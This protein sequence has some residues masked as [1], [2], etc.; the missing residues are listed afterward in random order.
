MKPLP[1]TT[2]EATSRPLKTSETIARLVARDIVRRGLQTGERLPGEAA[3]IEHYGVSRE[4]LREALRLLEVQGL[5]TIKRGVGGGPLVGRVDPANLGRIA[6]LFFYMA[7]GTYEELFQAWEMVEATLAEM[8]ARNPDRE[9]VRSA[10]EPFVTDSGVVGRDLDGFVR[11]HTDFHA[12]LGG[13]MGNRV[14]ELMLPTLGQIVTHHIVVHS[15]PRK[16]GDTIHGDH[17]AIARAVAS[18]QPSNARRL[19]AGHIRTMA[20]FFNDELG[21]APDLIDW[22]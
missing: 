21:A 2:G 5:I 4:S 10:M 15:D 22:K 20:A 19:M 12:V 17:V 14:L 8:A 9:A 18:R 7:G 16:L 13:L 3:M 11:G 1:I 6:S